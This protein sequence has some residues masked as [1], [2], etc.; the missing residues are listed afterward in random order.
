MA[1]QDLTTLT[2]E[3]VSSLVGSST[4]TAESIPDL[5]QSVY[6]S[7]VLIREGKAASEAKQARPRAS[8]AQIRKS[9]TPDAIISFIDG[10]GYRTLRRHLTTHGYT[11]ERYR[12][13]FGLP[14]D[15][16]LVAPNYSKA[17]SVLAKALGLGAG[18]R[19]RIDG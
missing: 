8:Q 5:I 17:R 6:G 4:V 7:L 1:D 11:P 19:K 18:G 13:E 15:Y 9:I 3:I 2:A 14:G 16:P 12:E 10:K